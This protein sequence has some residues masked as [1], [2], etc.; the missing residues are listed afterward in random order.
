MVHRAGDGTRTRSDADAYDSVAS[1]GDGIGHGLPFDNKLYEAGPSRGPCRRSHGDYGLWGE[2]R[3][4][5][6]D[7]RALLDGDNHGRGLTSPIAGEWLVGT[8]AYRR[9]R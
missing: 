1:R 7:T 3:A 4:D 2:W 5:P 8:D 9:A 6:A